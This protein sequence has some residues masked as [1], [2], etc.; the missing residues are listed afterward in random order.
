MSVS[1]DEMTGDTLARVNVVRKALG[2]QTLNEL[3]DARPGDT[4]DCLYFR[5]LKD[6]GAV[7]V[8]GNSIQFQSERQ[9]KIVAELWNT[10]VIE[11][12]TVASPSDVTRVISEFDSNRTPHYNV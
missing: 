12:A 4:K 9:A 8:G 7:N 3:P 2:F 6:V 1:F 11:G 10:E 5:A